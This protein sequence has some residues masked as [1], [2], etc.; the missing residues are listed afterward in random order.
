M[1]IE[2]RPL[3]R[4]RPFEKNARKIPKSAIDTVAKSLAEFGCRQPIVVDAEGVIIAGHVRYSAA[5]QLGWKEVP[6]HVADNLTSEQIRAY[7]IMDNRSNEETSWDLGLLVSEL[8]ELSGLSFDLG[9][10]GFSVAEL[11]ELLRKPVDEDPDFVPPLPEVPVSRRGDLWLMGPHC[12]LCGDST[13]A[14]DVKRVLGG[15]EPVLLIADPPYGVSLDGTWRDRARLNGCGPAEQPYMIERTPGHT[16]TT[17]SGDTRADWSEA[18]TLVPSVKSAYVWH[19]SA[20]ASVVQAGLE[21]AGFPYVQQLIWDKGRPV[22][23]RTH[24]WFQHEPCFYARKK[25]APWFGKPGE[26]STVWN[27]PS[28]KFIMGG[29]DEGKW[30]HPTQKPVVLM[31]RPIQ[32]HLRRGEFVYD[33]FLGSGTTLA[34]AELTDRV[35]VGLEIDPRYVDGIVTRWEHL[36]RKQAVLEGDGRSFEQIR[37]ERLAFSSGCEGREA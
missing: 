37:F 17:I 34:A 19:A 10:T 23:T 24:Y 21:R 31:E 15:R 36:T 4:I 16:R 22:L 6:V 27:S 30:D 5:L 32:N 11:D 20:H 33:P 2:V 12:V 9:L 3:G 14:E 25:K 18:Y 26:N 7:R 1:H 29:S 13:S 28:P 8:T 35:C